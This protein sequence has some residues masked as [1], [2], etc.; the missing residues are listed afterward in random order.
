[1]TQ[2]ISDIAFTPAV[3]AAQEHNGSRAGYARM[4]EKGG[5]ADS[6]TPDL[7]G[8]LSTRDSFYL[9]TA[10]ADGQPYIQ[11]R[12]GPRGFLKVID[13][14]TLA[15]ADFGGN[16]Q[17][18]S[19]GNLSENDKAYIFLMDYPNRRR[20]KIWG[21]AR[22]V[23]DD[24]DIR[25]LATVLL[26]GLGYQVLEAR[27]GEAALEAFGQAKA[28]DLLLTDVVLPGALSGPDLA[29]EAGSRDNDLK[30][31]FMSGYSED[32][33]R[34][35]GWLDKR[36]ELLPKIADG[37]YR[38]EDYIECDGVEAPRLHALRLT[39]TK[40]ADKIVLDF[41]GTDPEAKGPINWPIDYSDGR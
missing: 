14:R 17:F 1:M 2:P 32:A 5:W 6:V 28:I 34:L 18:I 30:I 39:M 16:R 8:F 11:H 4:E 15:F 36:A 10:N 13:A 24:A 40:T 35:S 33:M 27:N 22:V 12:G 31:V 25:Q 19:A 21:R 9:G 41:S 23:E 38:W 26:G 29:L 3:K 37:V 20:I 7:A